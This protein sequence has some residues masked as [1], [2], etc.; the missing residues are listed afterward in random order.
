MVRFSK[1]CRKISAI[2][3]DNGEPTATRENQLTP[4]KITAFNSLISTT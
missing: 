3:P 4:W 1:Y 2:K